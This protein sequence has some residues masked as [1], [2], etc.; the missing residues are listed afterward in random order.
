MIVVDL[1]MSGM[2]IL[3]CG[4]WQIGA[5]DTD[6]PDNTFC[7]EAR[8]EDEYEFILGDTNTQKLF[9]KSE[10]ELRDKNKQ[11]EKELLLHF[12]KWAEKSK[13]RN[14]VGHCIQ[15]DLAFLQQKAFKYNI[16]FPFSHRIFDT[17]AIASTKY[18]EMNGRFLMVKDK[19]GMI[20]D[21]GLKNVLKFVGMKDERIVHDALGDSKL[22]AEAFFRLVY[23]KNLL[24][25]YSQLKIPEYLIKK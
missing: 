5:I 11:S 16:N 8:V 19:L 25:E 15:Y 12:F 24:K 23:G 22:T 4:I 14:L 9:G 7:E 10:K 18:F 1:E 3:K 6:N 17:H 21:M 13:S 2:D 20:S